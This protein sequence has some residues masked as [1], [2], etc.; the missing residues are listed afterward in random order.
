MTCAWLQTV[1]WLHVVQR[2]QFTVDQ[3][4]QHSLQLGQTA[5]DFDAGSPACRS[6]NC[7][8]SMDGSV[9][10]G[11]ANWSSARTAITVVVPVTLKV[12]VASS[13]AV[14]V[15]FFDTTTG[16]PAARFDTIGSEE[17]LTLLIDSSSRDSSCSGVRQFFRR[18]GFLRRSLT[19]K[20]KVTGRLRA[21]VSASAVWVM[22]E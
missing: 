13:V 12:S 6:Q 15:A 10:I 19:W 9:S 8:P 7:A 11:F 14:T 3:I 5:G 20:S 21:M 2:I 17:L 16:R 4:Q 18:S 1:M 22:N